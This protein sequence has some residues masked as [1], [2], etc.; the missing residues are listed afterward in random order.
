MIDQVRLRNFKC[1]GNI[2]LALGPLTLLTGFNAAG[3]STVLQAILLLAQGVRQNV[4]RKRIHANGPLLRLGVPS[5]LLMKGATEKTIGIRL[6]SEG[7]FINW[8]LDPRSDDGSRLD[9]D[10]LARDAVGSE[11]ESGRDVARVGRPVIDTLKQAVYVSALRTPQGEFY[12][13]PDGAARIHADVGIEGQFAP[14]WFQEWMDEE[15]ETDRAYPGESA[16]TLRRQLNAWM[17]DTFG[18]VEFNAV[19]P[20]RSRMTWLEV[21]T[22][23]TDDWRLP[24]NV[25]YG[26]NYAF[27]I[28]VAGLLAKRDQTLI[29]DSPEAHL[30]PRAQSRIGGFLVHVAA[31][32]VRLIVETHSDHLLNGIRLAVREQRVKPDDV[33]IHFFDPRGL[34]D[35]SIAHVTTLIVGA[36]GE[37]S[38]WP[39]GFFDQSERDLASLAGWS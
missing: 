16:L 17:T 12:P 33:T 5:E 34:A 18:F 19:R 13:A 39:A 7:T 22:S 24:A 2:T 31:A 21:R 23:Q 1:F 28:F 4:W 30:H 37:I 6:Q 35:K 29:I 10:L 36:D 15:I 20:R 9:A 11:A 38:D 26:L 25:G 8:T 3:K 27:P 32:G 14:W